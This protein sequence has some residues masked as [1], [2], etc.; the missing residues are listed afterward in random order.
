MTTVVLEEFQLVPLARL[1]PGPDHRRHV[2]KAA[3]DDLVA[4]VREHGVLEPLLVRPH[5][6]NGQLEVVA[7]RRRLAAA[8][9]AKAETVPVRVKTLSDEEAAEVSIVENLQREDMHPLDESDGYA[10]L[11]LKAGRVDDVAARVGKSVPYVA[12]R[13]SLRRLIPD[14]RKAYAEGRIEFSGARAVARLSETG[15]RRVWD[16]VKRFRGEISTDH[17]ETRIRHEILLALDGAPWKKTDET[18]LPKAGAC[19]TCPKRTGAEPALFEDLRK[20]DH[21]TDPGCFE[22][23][24]VAH[25]QRVLAEDPK[26]ALVS[27]GWM[28]GVDEKPFGKHTIL[29]LRQYGSGDAIE[30]KAKDRDCERTVPAVVVTGERR[31][32]RLRVCAMKACPV[33]GRRLGQSELS[34]E[35]RAHRR[36]ELLA[37]EIEQRTLTAIAEGVRTAAAKHKA[38][39]WLDVVDIRALAMYVVRRSEQHVEQALC[40]L[41]KI[42]P[43]KRVQ[44]SARDAGMKKWIREASA[45]DITAFVLT[46][47]AATDLLTLRWRGG[48]ADETTRALAKRYGVNPETIAKAVTAEFKAKSRRAARRGRAEAVARKKAR[49]PAKIAASP[50]PRGRPKGSA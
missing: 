4:S 33:H 9:A 47:A 40:R 25:I 28:R 38:P 48:K 1:V 14:V 24:M 49:R 27:D 2:D 44:F 11:L 7:G 21:C 18:L 5:G 29:S 41:F 15:Q 34:E 22:A 39:D 36:K 37:R 50:A 6:S 13:L 35:G 16:E 3:F 26:T 32:H 43:D 10:Q 12:A 8:K 46:A 23:K 30:I 20:G 31:G 17:L 45:S 19:S 42:E